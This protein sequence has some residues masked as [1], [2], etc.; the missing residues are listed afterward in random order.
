[1]DALNPNN[2]LEQTIDLEA[3]LDKQRRS[4]TAA[5]FPDAKQ[6][7]EKLDKLYRAIVDN[8]Q[9]L[10]DVVSED[11]GNR[12]ESETLIAEIVP[13]LDGIKYYKSRLRGW[14]K[15][16]KRHTPLMWSFCPPEV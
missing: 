3:V 1:M 13:L 5:P 12:S 2:T 11:F 10:L 9:L 16:Q 14:M 4:F 8:K 15:P 6:R 7:I